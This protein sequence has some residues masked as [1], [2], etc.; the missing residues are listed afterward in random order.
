MN[1]LTQQED[2]RDFLAWLDLVRRRCRSYAYQWYNEQQLKRF[3]QNEK[4]TQEQE[5]LLQDVQAPQNGMGE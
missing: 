3:C 1:I 5:T 4:E 2:A